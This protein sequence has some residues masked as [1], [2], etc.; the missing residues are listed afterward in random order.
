MHADYFEW[1]HDVR[2][3]HVFQKRCLHLQDKLTGQTRQSR[4]ER[5]EVQEAAR[6]A[7]DGQGPDPSAQQPAQLPEPERRLLV[8]NAP[9]VQMSTPHV[10]GDE[11]NHRHT[12]V[13]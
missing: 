12:A 6:Q 7:E 13:Q 5:Q 10:A 8:R 4:S 9:A 11:L 1:K 3:E 2:S